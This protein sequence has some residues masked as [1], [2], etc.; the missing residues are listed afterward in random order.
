MT[1]R[2]P[3]TPPIRLRWS[4]PSARPGRAEVERAI[5]A[6]QDAF[7][8]WRDT[9]PRERAEYLV[10]AA[11]VARRRI[12]RTRRLAGA[13]G[14]Q[15]VGPGLRGRGRGHRL[16]RILRARDDPAGRAALYGQR[17]GRSESVLLR[18]QG[19]GGRHRPLE[20]PAGDQLRDGAAAIVAG[21]CVVYKPSR[22]SPVIGHTCSRSSGRPACR[23]ASSTTSPAAA[24]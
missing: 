22:A 12:L 4:A 10:K 2:R 9:S 6:A 17:A 18:A 11:A 16:P 7:P 5:G 14:R 8:G 20:L 3:S 21:N 23:L 1:A 15:A 24:A 13:G 19:G